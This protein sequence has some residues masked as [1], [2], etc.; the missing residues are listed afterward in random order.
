MGTTLTD[1]SESET[2]QNGGDLPR[3]ENGDVT[4]RPSD[5]DRLRADEL[6]IE[7]GRAVLKQHGDD[8][9]EVL[10]EFVQRDGPGSAHQAT[11]ELSL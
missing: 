7:L 11:P 3:L 9:L 5:L 10:A 6:A 2:H 1:L 8:L 4:H